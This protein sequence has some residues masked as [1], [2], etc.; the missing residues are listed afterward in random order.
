MFTDPITYL[1][2]THKL[3]KPIPIPYLL[4]YSL[5]T[6]GQVQIRSRWLLRQNKSYYLT[7]KLWLDR[8]EAIDS[9]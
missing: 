7:L 9:G 8:H 2:P 6:L 1:P 4:E 3:L 5:S